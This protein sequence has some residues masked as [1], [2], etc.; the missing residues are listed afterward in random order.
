ME[1]ATLAVLTRAATGE[2]SAGSAAS[3]GVSAALPAGAITVATRI[4][5]ISSSEIRERVRK[6]LP[7]HGFVTETVERFIVERA[8]YKQGI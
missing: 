1:L 3:K 5:D 6:G 8:L 4:I 2:S 7:I